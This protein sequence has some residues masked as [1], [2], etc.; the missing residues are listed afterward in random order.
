M[1]DIVASAIF[2][3]T[4]SEEEL[5][6]ILE[7]ALETVPHMSPIN[8]HITN[9]VSVEIDWSLQFQSLIPTIG[10]AK[11]LGLWQEYWIFEI[12]HHA[13]RLFARFL[14]NCKVTT[15]EVNSILTGLVLRNATSKKELLRVAKSRGVDEHVVE[16]VLHLLELT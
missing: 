11:N 9:D 12:R 6:D 1:I 13:F 7:A 10:R 15:E 8:L 5:Q 2:D 3:R 4:M 16:R 14:L